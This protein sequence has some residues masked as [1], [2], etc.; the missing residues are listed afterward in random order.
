MEESA[1]PQYLLI[2]ETENGFWSFHY[3]LQLNFV[4]R[5][6]SGGIPADF[7]YQLSPQGDSI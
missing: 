4:I 5:D 1:L 6:L 3:S 2:Y 7:M